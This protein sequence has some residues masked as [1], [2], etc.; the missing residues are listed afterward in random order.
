MMG[1]I[2]ICVFALISA[3][4]CMTVSRSS[5]GFRLF[6]SAAAC[7]MILLRTSDELSGILSQI[8]SI[9]DE[10]SLDHSY[11]LILIKGL[12][13]CYITN[14]AVSVCRDCGETAIASQTLL[15]GRIAL[16]VIS[17]PML[18]DL[19]EIIKMLLL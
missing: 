13:I 17:L 16:L 14:F 6:I 8:R 5:A 9:F 15:A 2:A 1:I 3:V 11:V 10:S 18:E 4:I 7:A 19:I 12:G